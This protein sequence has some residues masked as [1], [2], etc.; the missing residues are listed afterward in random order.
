VTFDSG[1]SR[2]GPFHD[3]FIHCD[4]VTP[5][6]CKVMGEGLTIR[7]GFAYFLFGRCMIASTDRGLCALK[8]VGHVSETE[9]RESHPR[10]G[11]GSRPSATVQKDTLFTK[12]GRHARSP[13]ER[14]CPTLRRTGSTK[15]QPPTGGLMIRPLRQVVRSDRQIN[16]N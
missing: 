7:F 1:L 11:T 4:A 10:S 3:L 9:M 2:P 5:G 8:S 12:P 6:E 16:N 14:K 13:G 15:T